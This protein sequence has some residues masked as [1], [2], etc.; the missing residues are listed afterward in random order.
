[1]EG[2]GMSSIRKSASF[3]SRI[4]VRRAKAAHQRRCHSP[5]ASGLMNS[6]SVSAITRHPQPM[7]KKR[8]KGSHKS[9]K[10]CRDR[11]F[12]TTSSSSSSSS[13][14]SS[15]ES[16][17]SQGLHPNN[18]IGNKVSEKHPNLHV[19][20]MGV[21]IITNLLLSHSRPPTCNTTAPG[22]WSSPRM[23]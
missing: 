13:Y 16:V 1:M 9:I 7:K 6:A 22:K 11:R 21:I 20:Y 15:D 18:G 19:K 3:R 23:H 5:P 10:K 8:L 4:P 2:M 14:S 17:N 12:P